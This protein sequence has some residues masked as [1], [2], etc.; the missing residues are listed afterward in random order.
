MHN[1]RLLGI[2]WKNKIQAKICKRMLIIGVTLACA[3][4]CVRLHQPCIDVGM[5]ML[6]LCEHSLKKILFCILIVLNIFNL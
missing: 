6:N 2:I 5:L 3:C 4:F 1:V